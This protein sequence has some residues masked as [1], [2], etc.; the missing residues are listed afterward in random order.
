M[1]SVNREQFASAVASAI[2]SVQH[3][4]REIDRLIVGVREMLSEAPDSL[5]PVPGTLGKLGHNQGRFV[6]RNEYGVLFAPNSDEDDA[7]DEEEEELDDNADEVD[8]E[9]G[10]GRRKRPPAEIVSDQPLLAVRVAIYD[11]QRT[12][13][14]EPQIQFALMNKW[15]LGK[16][17]FASGQRFVLARSMLRRV[18]RSLS[19]S[20]GVPKGG[21]LITRAKIKRAVGGKKSGDRQLSCTL[22]A[23]VEAVPLFSLDT[24]NALRHLTEQM[25]AMWR[26]HYH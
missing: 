16:N 21:R 12:D 4:Y 25:K 9:L 2:S 3:L 26:A 15:S 8:E 20:S 7:E 14:F 11:A 19:M 13:S 18:P 6:I 22:P 24:P 17:G 5:V 1:S 23:G 10:A